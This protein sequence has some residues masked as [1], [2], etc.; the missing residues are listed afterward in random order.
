MVEI[1]SHLASVKISDARVAD[2]RK[3]I[4]SILLKQD[5]I[6]SKQD[7]RTIVGIRRS[8]WYEFR[9]S[10]IEVELRSIGKD[11]IINVEASPYSRFFTGR[12]ILAIFISANTAKWNLERFLESIKKLPYKIRVMSRA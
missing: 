8:K 11:C 7:K 1:T 2:L 4:L 10:A 12:D 6:I 5:F 9:R 3:E